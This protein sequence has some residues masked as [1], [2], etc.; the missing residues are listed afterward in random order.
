MFG[1]STHCLHNRP[2]EEALECL[3]PVTG[4]VEVMADGYHYLESAEVLEGFDFRYFIHAPARSVNISS[5]LEPIRKASVEVIGR[6]FEIAGMVDADVVVHPGYD[7]WDYEHE[8]SLN[9]MKISLEELKQVAE[10]CSITFFVENMPNWG[11]FILRFPQELPLIGDLGLALDVGHAFLNGCLEEF[12]SHPIAHFHIHDNDGKDDLHQAVG[13]G[14]ID[15]GPVMDAVRRNNATPII[16]VNGF[17][18]VQRSIKA[19]EQL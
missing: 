17:D 11:H 16:E 7:A 15:F 14:I 12:L 4:I 13:D 10:E 1:V 19:L 8:R 3:A 18:A 2:L 6:C 9:Q 5:N